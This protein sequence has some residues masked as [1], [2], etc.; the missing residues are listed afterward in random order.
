MLRVHA[1]YESEDLKG[2]IY[3]AHLGIYVG[4]IL[5]RTLKK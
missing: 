4:V 1:K 5:K 3:L 2:S